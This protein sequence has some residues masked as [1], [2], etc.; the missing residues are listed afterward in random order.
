MRR[1]FLAVAASVTVIGG[2]SALPAG[3]TAP[4]KN[5][6]ITFRRFIDDVGVLFTIHPDGT[7]ERRV[8]TPPEG[9]TDDFPDFASD[10][11]L[12]GFQRCAEICQ[13]MVVRPDGSGLRRV[14]TDDDNSDVALS[15]DVRRV[16]FTRHYGIRDDML[17]HHDIY[18]ARLSGGGVRRV[19]RSPKFIGEDAQVQWSPDGRRLVFTRKWW[20]GDEVVKQALFIVNTDGSGLRRLTPFSLRAGDGADWSPDG[21]RILFRSPETP[22][23]LGTNLFT[24]RTDGSGLRQVTHQPPDTTVYSASFSPDGRSITAALQGVDGKADVYTMKT[25]GTHITPV[26]RTTERDSA[27]DW[28]GRR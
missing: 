23:F 22:D 27:P 2:L 15:P 5:G 1:M 26:T 8:L 24:I 16:A 14:G 11:S 21:K 20:S 25:D 6:D 17:V 13:A 4:G 19:T 18:T 3:A 28:G 7:G 12:I 9:S 10:G